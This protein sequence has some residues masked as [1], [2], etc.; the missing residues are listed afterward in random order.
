MKTLEKLRLVKEMITLLV[1]YYFNKY[2]KMIAI[3]LSK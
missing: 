1:A 3:D 2:Y